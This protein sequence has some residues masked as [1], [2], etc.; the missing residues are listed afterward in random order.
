[1]KRILLILVLAL[2]SCYDDDSIV[3][4]SDNTAHIS[5][6]LTNSMKSIALHDASFDDII[7]NSSC[8]SLEFPY[9]VVVNAELKT[10]NSK[11]DLETLHENDE[12]EIVYPVSAVLFNYDKHQITS[13]SGYEAVAN[14]C[15]QNFNLSPHRCLDFEY[16]V[17]IKMYNQV[18]SSFQSMNMDHDQDLYT[19]LDN[20]HETDIYEIDY[21]II[22]NDHT[23]GTSKSISSNADFDTIFSNTPENCQ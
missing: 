12:I 17:T 21:P 9:Q 19:F 11:A 3:I 2:V 13:I 14:A 20:L 22:L 15:E 7:D 1:M 18:G 6:K 23:T 10:I 4:V 16:P 8:F 5:A